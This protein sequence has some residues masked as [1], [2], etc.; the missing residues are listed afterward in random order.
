MELRQLEYV[1]TVAEE[2][3]FRRAA[4]RMHVSQQSVGE[5]IRLERELGAALFARTASAWR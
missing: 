2:L 1:L 5:Q 3:H 4:E